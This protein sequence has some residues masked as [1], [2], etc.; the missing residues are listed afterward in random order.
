[1][2]SIERGRGAVSF[3][4]GFLVL[5]CHTASDMRCHAPVGGVKLQLVELRYDT[6]VG[7]DARLERFRLWAY[8][9]YNWEKLT[10]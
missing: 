1:M 4:R 6:L 3:S 10:R 8:G 5:K 9:K 7:E 2:D